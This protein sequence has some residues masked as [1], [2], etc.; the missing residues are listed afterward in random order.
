M[1]IEGVNGRTDAKM[2]KET[3]LPT[4]E[5]FVA[6]WQAS[7]VRSWRNA[8]PY[9]LYLSG[10]ALYAVIAQAVVKL[11]SDDFWPTYIGNIVI[12][13]NAPLI[14]A[15]VYVFLVPFVWATVYWR[16][17][18]RSIR[19]PQCGDWLAR[20]DSGA[21]RGPNPKWKSVSQTGVC[22]KC[23]QRLLTGE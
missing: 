16:L 12:V 9:A 4:P 5:E 22:G 14:L 3:T 8:L 2:K 10:F 17:Y 19:C 21:W 23:G 20:D 13:W 6:F 15:V 1:R 18:A 11:L 7:E